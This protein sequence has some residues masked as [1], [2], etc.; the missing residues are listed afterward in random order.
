MISVLL[1]VSNDLLVFKSEIPKSLL[2][3]LTSTCLTALN[4][5][6]YCLFCLFSLFY[7]LFFPS[8]LSNTF[9]HLSFLS[10]SF[11]VYN[12]THFK[13]FSHQKNADIYISCSNLSQKHI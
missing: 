8:C 10:S 7:S 2:F 9:F 5:S 11:I 1:K 12:L 6:N 4:T 13:G 3:L